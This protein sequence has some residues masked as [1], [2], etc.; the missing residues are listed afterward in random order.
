M[1]ISALCDYYDVLDKKGELLPAGYSCEEISYYVSL[2]SDGRITGMIDVRDTAEKRP[3]K[4]IMPK[5]TVTTKI[6][7]YVIDHR[8]LYIF[9]LNP[10]GSG[11]ENEPPFTEKDNRNKAK[12]SHAAFCRTNLEFIDGIDTPV[13]NAYRKFI[14][15]WEPQY[16]TGN[17]FLKGLGK[18]YSSSYYSFCLN[19][20]VSNPIHNNHLIKEKWDMEYKNSLLKS[21]A[22]GVYA[23]CAVYGEEMPIARVHAGVRGIYDGA[24][25]GNSLSSCKWDSFCSYGLEQS[26]NSNVSVEAMDKYVCALNYLLEHK[27]GKSNKF[28][29][30]GVTVLYWAADA[31]ETADDLI[32]ASM[33]RQSGALSAEYTAASLSA[34]ASAKRASDVSFAD[35]DAFKHINPRVTFCMAGIKPNASR[36]S[37]K[38]MYKNRLGSIIYNIAKFQEDLKIYHPGSYKVVY[39]RRIAEELVSPHYKSADGRLGSEKPNPAL[40]SNILNAIVNGSNLPTDLLETLVTRVKLDRNP[41]DSAENR[42]Y[43]DINGNST[44]AG[45]IKACLNRTSRLKGKKEEI[46]LALDRTNKD[47]AYLCGRLFAVLERL[48]QESSGGS[49]NRTI[50]DS[51]FSD[52]A[53]RPSHAFPSLIM[54]SQHNLKSFA[55]VNLVSQKGEKVNKRNFNKLIGEI[56]NDLEGEFP[57]SLN[58]KQQGTFIIGYYHQYQDFFVRKNPDDNSA[59]PN[60]ESDDDEDDL[61]F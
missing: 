32:T 23:Q 22:G 59:A 25:T 35:I 38:F 48:Q 47:P 18:E 44:R 15:S 1:L 5:R 46:T 41:T 9:G 57:D 36:L 3:R 37:I 26:Y 40:M 52:A 2:N 13:V 24:F 28:N 19:G 16:E 45:L 61:P 12:N 54:L 55:S 53:S 39:L 33:F 14:E 49:M 17:E 43:V 58:V 10:S 7:S 60:A 42:Q 34:V 8:P 27:E 51:H 30:G 4:E 6:S 29:M 50:K 11:K 21:S 20:D 56:I 31:N